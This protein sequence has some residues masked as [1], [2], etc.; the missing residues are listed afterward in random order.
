MT[1]GNLD[2]ALLGRFFQLGYIVRDLVPAMAHFIDRYGPLKF[3]VIEG[4][5]EYPHTRRIALGYVG[6]VMIELIEPD[7]AVPSVYV[8]YVPR[9]ANSARFHHTGHFVE[10]YADTVRRLE[11]EGYDVPYKLSYGDVMDCCYADM[12][13]DLGHY[14]EYVRLGEDGKK[15]FSSIPGFVAFP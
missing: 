1:T 2:G 11:H 4:Q 10:S 15:W 3:Q 12:R 9:D 5:P 6:P 14:V 7:P 13:A 8:D